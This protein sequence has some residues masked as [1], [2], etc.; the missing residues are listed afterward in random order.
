[1]AGGDEIE[2]TK[3]SDNHILNIIRMVKSY[4]KKGMLDGWGYFDSEGMPDGDFW[5][6]YGKDVIE[7]FNN[8]H[9]YKNVLTEAKNRNIYGNV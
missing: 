6:I 3:M 9:G 8:N 2:V 4:A 7:Y 1:M 5:K